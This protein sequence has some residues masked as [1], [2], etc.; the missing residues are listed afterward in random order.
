MPEASA[1]KRQCEKQ[2]ERYL[3]IPNHILNLT[4]L[5]LLDKVLLAHFYSFGVRGCWQSN[6]TLGE[7][8]MTSAS[9][10]TRSIGV[11]RKAALISVRAPKGRYRTI[12]ARNNPE[13]QAVQMLHQSETAQQVKQ[14]R[15][16]ESS[17][18]AIEVRRQ[19]VATNNTTITENNK[20]TTAT[21]PPLP[22]AGQASSLLV[23][24]A[25]ERRAR[26]EAFSRRFG[27]ASVPRASLSPQ[28]FEQRRQKQKQAL[29]AGK[30]LSQKHSSGI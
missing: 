18:T 13:V 22:A 1:K 26:L 16:I 9:T 30:M 12:W 7:I 27:L 11:L 29:L 10:I 21:P 4:G 14:N 28:D 8:F 20:D 6:A 19:C 15:P 2:Q 5:R 23:D 17:D 24:R 3:R 25:A